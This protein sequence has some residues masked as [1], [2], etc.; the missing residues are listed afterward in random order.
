MF[1]RNTE[2]A[3][4][5]DEQIIAH[6]E[7]TMREKRVLDDDADRCSETDEEAVKQ[8]QPNL[9]QQAE[10]NVPKLLAQGIMSTLFTVDKVKNYIT[11]QDIYQYK[12]QHGL[13]QAAPQQQ[14]RFKTTIQQEPTF[15]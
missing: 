5:D 8:Q 12:K 1:Q 2:P 11:A 6:Y 7:S 15:S 3:K 13:I 4:T 9:H 10:K 14:Q